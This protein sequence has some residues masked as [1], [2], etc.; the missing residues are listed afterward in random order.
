MSF[1]TKPEHTSY[2]GEKYVLSKNVLGTKSSMLCM[3]L[4]VEN[5]P[6]SLPNRKKTTVFGQKKELKH[7]TKANTKQ[8]T[9]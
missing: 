1:G 8:R 4:L 9:N 2:K 5:P 6:Y 3:L 7:Q